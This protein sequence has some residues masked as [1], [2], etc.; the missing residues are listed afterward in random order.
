MPKKTFSQAITEL[1]DI[2]NAIER[3]DISLEES[4]KLY[5]EGIK[6][7]ITCAESLNSIEKEIIIL[8]EKADGAFNQKEILEE[9]IGDLNNEI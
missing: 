5:K 6:L 7:S 8:Q 9:N 1:S 3:G 4:V 2:V